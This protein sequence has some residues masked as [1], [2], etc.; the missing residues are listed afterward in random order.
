MQLIHHFNILLISF[1]FSAVENSR[2]VSCLELGRVDHQ[3]WLYR[4]RDPKRF[5][6]S[7]RWEKRWFILKVKPF[8]ENHYLVLTGQ[9]I[10]LEKLSIRISGS[11]C[12]ESRLF[13]ISTRLSCLSCSRCQIKTLYI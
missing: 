2:R 12:L 13:N 11:R 7:Y 9:T 6:P 1:V 3:G 5:I 4:R 8:I 10:F